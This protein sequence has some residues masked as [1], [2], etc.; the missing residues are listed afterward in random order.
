MSAQSMIKNIM[1]NIENIKKETKEIVE[2]SNKL[3]NEMY[4][5]MGWKRE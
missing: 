4:E 1:E 2:R 3:I 5:L